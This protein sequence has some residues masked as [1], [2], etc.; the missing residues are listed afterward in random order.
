M[1]TVTI[2]SGYIEVSGHAEEPVVCHG[3]SAISQMVANYAEDHKFGRVERGD[4]Y[5]IIYDTGLGHYARP[6]VESFI[7][8]IV[9]ISE[10][11]PG[12]IIF[13]YKNI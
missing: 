13:K 9:D 11:Y 6:L 8:A 10:E 5:L 7:S 2:G 4:G 3:V 12:N 1:T